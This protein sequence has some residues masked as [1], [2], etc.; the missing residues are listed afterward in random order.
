MKRKLAGSGTHRPVWY[1]QL[2]W[3]ALLA[4]C[5]CRAQVSPNSEILW[6]TYGVPHIYAESARDMFYAY[7]RA[8]ITHHTDLILK[9]YAQARGHAS[10][11][12]GEDLVESD[13]L[14]HL[15]DLPGR[16]EALYSEQPE[17][18]RSCLDA[19]A[20]GI[21][22]Y[23]LANP[24]T[25]S[26]AYRGIAPV[27]ATDVIGH[28]LRVMYLEFLAGEDIHGIRREASAGSNAIAIAPL[29]SESGNAML[30]INPHLPWYDFYTWF[31]SHLNY[32]GYS[33]YGIALVGM[34]SIVMG[35]N[36]NLGWAHTI[37][38]IDAADRYELTLESDHSYRF[39][40]EIVPFDRR[41]VSIRVKQKDG[42]LAERELEL[43]YSKHGPVVGR[44]AGR[45][46]SLR[47]AGI[48]TGLMKQYFDMGSARDLEEFEHAL[49]QM[50]I[51]MFNIIYADRDGNIFYLFNGN[52]PVRE[53]GDFSFWKGTIDGSSSEHIWNRIHP[54]G[55]LP[56]LLNPPTG[57][58][59][60]CN[61]APWSCTFPFLLNRTDYPSYFS[62]NSF[63]LRAQRA[64]LLVKDDPAVTFDRLQEYKHNTLMEAAARFL[65]DLLQAVEEYPEPVA[66]KAAEILERWDMQT[67]V[68]SR[69]AVLFAHW[70][71]KMGGR[72]PGTPWDPGAPLETPDG[73]RERKEAVV[74]LAE[75]AGEIQARYGALDIP[76]GEVYRFRMNGIDL[77]ANGGP[78]DQFGLFRTIYYQDSPGHKKTAVAGETF[79]AIV[80]FGHKTR[81]MV[82]LSY[83][84]ASQ[85][86]NKHVGDQLVLMSEK[87]LRP[88]LL[89]RDE[90]LQHLERQESLPPFGNEPLK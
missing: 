15:F 1:K 42:T 61:D 69:G 55:D 79:T 58:I 2:I 33:V 31:E 17:D 39:D 36:R 73:I 64:T 43:L 65:D 60:N 23:I 72:R 22:D 44:K 68:S 70:W 52:I 78:G 14:V 28:V 85:K 49:K 18:Y 82:A 53:K 26:E 32:P 38:P 24:L 67:E 12:M 35:F 16:A 37:N 51:P 87:R 50:Q 6:D 77:P 29:K 74:L 63:T 41:S 34:P 48:S 30:L 5:A 66:C 75:A 25:V 21:N 83:G 20:T 10:E 59:Q 47:I 19:F 88:A 9:L 76:W 86:G 3:F 54:Y 90:V 4:T 8:Q 46:Y 45:A 84:N 57:F 89:E 13:R 81:A 62:S 7:G 40:G 80:E 11:T 71:E 27:T 56:K